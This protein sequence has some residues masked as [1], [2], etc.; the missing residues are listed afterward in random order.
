MGHY[1]FMITE[2]IL[3]TTN[4]VTAALLVTSFLFN[5]RLSKKYSIVSADPQRKAD[6]RFAE[7]LAKGRGLFYIE[8]LDERDVYLRRS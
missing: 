2:I 6:E 1:F 8:K 4:V 3:I 5:L 7:L